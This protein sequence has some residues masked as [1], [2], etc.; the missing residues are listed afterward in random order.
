MKVENN[1]IF[2]DDRHKIYRKEREMSN[3]HEFNKR[4]A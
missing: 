3:G 1:I 4:K 2:Y